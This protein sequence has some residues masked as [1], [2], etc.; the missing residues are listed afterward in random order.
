MTRQQR[1]RARAAGWE[2]ICEAVRLATS[3]S[4]ADREHLADLMTPEELAL[5]G[6]TYAEFRVRLLRW[7]D[8]NCPRKL[9]E[10]ADK[11]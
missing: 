4:G 2:A 7:L 1:Q 5:A 8:I 3:D 6:R 9:D 10:Q 11:R